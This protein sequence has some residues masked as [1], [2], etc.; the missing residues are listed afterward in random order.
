MPET[1]LKERIKQGLLLL[2]GAMG[3]QL[4]ARGIQAGAFILAKSFPVYMRPT[5]KRA[6]MRLLLT[7]SVPIDI[8]CPGMDSPKRP[9]A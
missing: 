6:V 1:S 9:P 7:L 2:D 8:L 3:T 5:C 4:I